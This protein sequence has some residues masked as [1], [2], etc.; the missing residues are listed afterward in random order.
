MTTTHTLKNYPG[1]VVRFFWLYREQQQKKNPKLDLNIGRVYW[2]MAG[3]LRIY[4]IETLDRLTLFDNSNQR[5]LEEF[6]QAAD[7]LTRE[8]Y[9]WN[10]PEVKP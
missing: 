9:P 6:K 10:F 4:G 8:L 7:E 1:E 2:Y 3:S 5:T